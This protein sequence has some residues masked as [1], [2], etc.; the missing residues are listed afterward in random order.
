MTYADQYF[1]KGEREQAALLARQIHFLNDE[2]RSDMDDQIRDVLRRTLVLPEAETDELIAQVCQQATR[3]LTPDEWQAVVKRDDISY[4]PC[5]DLPGS[6]GAAEFVLRLRSDPMRTDEVQHLSLYVKADTYAGTYIA[7]RFDV[8]KEGQVVVDHATGLMWQQSGSQEALTY[9]EAEQYCSDQELA[10]H[11]GWRLPTV[12]E[13]LSLVEP[14]ESPDGLYIDLRFDS[15]QR[16]V[17]SA[18]KRQI[19][20][21][22]SSE[23]AWVV[24]FTSGNVGWY[25]L[26][27]IFYVRCVRSGQ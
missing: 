27:I 24:G 21:E 17:L 3:N 2:Y 25:S 9:Q 7:N 4:A 16:Y 20:D 8:Q 5:P 22:D 18:D 19:K 13:L 11:T 1:I 12:E 23:S 10:D 14:E 26:S 15:A 6:D